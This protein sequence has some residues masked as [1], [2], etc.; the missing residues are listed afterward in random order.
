MKKYAIIKTGGK[1]YRV[2]EKQDLVVEKINE[3]VGKKIEFNQVLLVA[4]DK[5]LL[6]GNPLV[7]N[8][9]VTAQIKDQEKEKKISV[10]KFKA[11]SRYRRKTGHR[12]AKTRVLIDK[13]ILPTKKVR[14]K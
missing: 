9:K 2:G 4:E 11:K 10:V 6:I 1:Q 7:K 3:L 5:R 14:E 13:I 12:Q 8:A